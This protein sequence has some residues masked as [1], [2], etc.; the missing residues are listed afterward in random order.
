[1]HYSVVFH[2]ETRKAVESEDLCGIKKYLKKEKK[3]YY[4]VLMSSS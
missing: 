2:L 1:M 3:R 4:E